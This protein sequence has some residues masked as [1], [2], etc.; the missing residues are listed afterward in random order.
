M[1]RSIKCACFCANYST[2][3]P[4]PK[5]K[6]KTEMPFKNGNITQIVIKFACK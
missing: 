5:R 1:L 6:K 4:L 3:S 2:I